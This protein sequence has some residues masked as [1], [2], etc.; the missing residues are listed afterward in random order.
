MVCLC[1]AKWYTGLQKQQVLDL[2]REFPPEV[3][4]WQEAKKFLDPSYGETGLSN[5]YTAPC[6]DLQRSAI[7]KHQPNVSWL[8]QAMQ[9]DVSDGLR[10]G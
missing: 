1:R 7:L 6:T 9:N 3:Q 5:W 8:K 2:G 10:A 4:T